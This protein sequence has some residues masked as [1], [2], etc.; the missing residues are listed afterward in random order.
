MSTVLPYLFACAFVALT[1]P[2]IIVA[3]RALPWVEQK[4]LAGIRPWACDICMSFWTVAVIVAAITGPFGWRYAFVAGP[5]YSICL[6]ILGVLQ[7]SLPPPMV[8]TPPPP[9]TPEPTPLADA[10]EPKETNP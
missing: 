9:F 10:L 1:A 4:M 6:W 3:V 5:A 7:Q 8:A 2:G